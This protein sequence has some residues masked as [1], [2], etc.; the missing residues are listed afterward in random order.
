MS[1]KSSVY[2]AMSLDGFIARKDG[3][4]DWLDNANAT[5]TAGE[6]CGYNTFMASVDY[7]I[8]GRNTYEKILS[9]GPWPYGNKMVIVLSSKKIDFAD[10]LA[11]SV[12]WSSESPG[13]LYSRLDKLGAGRLYI[14]GGITIQRFLE[15]GLINDITI[16]II[17]ILLGTGKS[18]F[19]DIGRDIVLR[20]KQTKTY[21]FGFVQI[22]YEVDQ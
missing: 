10:D 16:T 14:D 9:F 3:Q 20:H 5:V 17:P 13:K 12:F 6:D 8:M 15:E 1:L 22:S 18:L 19:D 4:L 11:K 2:I 7:L 21:D